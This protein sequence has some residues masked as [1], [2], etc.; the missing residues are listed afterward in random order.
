MFN[1]YY[2]KSHPVFEFVNSLKLYALYSYGFN[3]HCNIHDLLLHY[4]M[5]IYWHIEVL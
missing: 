2:F 5:F 1:M 4:T 3:R